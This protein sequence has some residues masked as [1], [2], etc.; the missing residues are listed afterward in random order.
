MK[1][2]L[3]NVADRQDPA[4]QQADRAGTLDRKID[5]AELAA[6]LAHSVSKQDVLAG[7]LNVVE[8][9]GNV[10]GVGAAAQA[11]F[12]TTAAS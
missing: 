8:F 1:N 7:Y 4:A 3:I 11:Y 12:G 9:T 2:Y 5:E 10:Y 6:R